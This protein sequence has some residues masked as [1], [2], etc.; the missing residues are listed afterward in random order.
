MTSLD[1]NTSSNNHANDSSEPDTTATTASSVTSPTEAR[2]PGSDTLKKSLE[3]V[4]VDFTQNT[5][6]LVRKEDSKL[7]VDQFRV[8]PLDLEFTSS[9]NSATEA[10]QPKSGGSCRQATIQSVPNIQHAS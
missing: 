10:G 3:G 1:A 9:R 5:A 6:L 4:K 2:Q 8:I 7:T